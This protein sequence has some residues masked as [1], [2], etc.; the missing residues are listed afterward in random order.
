M[1]IQIS[2]K[3][4]FKLAKKRGLHENKLFDLINILAE[5]DEPLGPKFHNHKL[6]DTPRFRN[7]WECHIEPDWLLVYQKNGKD[8]IL[9][10]METGTHCDLFGF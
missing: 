10:L 1:S 9:L 6:S 2:L 5:S 7:C 3:K 8:L 4:Q